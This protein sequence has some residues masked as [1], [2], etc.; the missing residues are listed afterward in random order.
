MGLITRKIWSFLK[1]NGY[2]TK[3]NRMQIAVGYNRYPSGKIEH[4]TD[5]LLNVILGLIGI[6]AGYGPERSDSKHRSYIIVPAIKI[7]NKKLT[8]AVKIQHIDKMRISV[9]IL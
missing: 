7:N 2:I 3:E 5:T 4:K 1:P 9:E 8:P 6:E